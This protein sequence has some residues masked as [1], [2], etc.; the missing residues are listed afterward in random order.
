MSF[1]FVLTLS[2][3]FNT[4][5][6]L[7]ALHAKTGGQYTA[8]HSEPNERGSFRLIIGCLITLSLCVWSAIHLNVP[9]RAETTGK[10]HWLWYALERTKWVSIGVLAPE[11]VV[12]T[13]GRQW[14]SARLLAQKVNKSM[15]EVSLLLV[16]CQVLD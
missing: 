15:D 7:P 6:S 5:S 2:Q 3:L 9:R 16:I 4:V 8:W 1:V 11:L 10:K 12:Y 13:A 14:T